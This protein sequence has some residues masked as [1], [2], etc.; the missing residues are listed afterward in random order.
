[1]AAVTAAAL[2]D[3]IVLAN[4][5]DGIEDGLPIPQGKT[6][7]LL[8]HLLEL[9]LRQHLGA[10]EDVLQTQPLDHG[11]GL[12]LRPSADGEQA[13]AVVRERPRHDAAVVA[14]HGRDRF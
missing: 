10:D 12:P 5:G 11:L 2:V 7:G 4:A 6:Q 13:S 14:A 8:A 1:M 9:G 3:N